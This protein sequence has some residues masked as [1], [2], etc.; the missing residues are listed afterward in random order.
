VKLLSKARQQKTTV[1]PKTFNAYERKAVSSGS[2]RFRHLLIDSGGGETN[3]DRFRRGEG[4][5]WRSS[6]RRREGGNKKRDHRSR[7]EY[8][9]R[10][11]QGDNNFSCKNAELE[12]IPRHDIWLR[13]E[14][15]EEETG[16]RK[17]ARNEENCRSLTRG[18][19]LLSG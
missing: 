1:H 14:I 16:Q 10:E 19:K 18:N 3:R 12:N 11:A 6:A 4:E 2:K 9:S 5:E 17:G 7:I 15:F 13:L 8:S